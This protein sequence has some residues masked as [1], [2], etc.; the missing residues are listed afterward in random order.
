MYIH[1]SSPQ[2]LSIILYIPF[3]SSCDEGQNWSTY[4]FTN[5][6]I[7]QRIYVVRMFTE[8]GEESHHATIF[9]YR[10]DATYTNFEWL[11]IDL[12]FTVLNISNCNASDYYQWRP[13][14]EVSQCSISTY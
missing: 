7:S 14:D 5:A 6:S 9:G 10:P 1:I 8:Y 3:R 13:T 12:D 2:S 4:T 11:V